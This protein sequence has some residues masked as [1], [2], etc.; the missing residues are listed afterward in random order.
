MISQLPLYL[1]NI[2]VGYRN[3]LASDIN[4]E[5][6]PREFVTVMG[7]N[8]FG[9]TTL[10]DCLM[11]LSSPL[12]GDIRF[13]GRLYSGQFRHEINQRVGWVISQKENYPLFSTVDVFLK[14]IAPLYTTWNWDFCHRL[15][16]AFELDTRKKLF[17]LSMGEH[18]KVR[19]VKALSFEPSLIVLDELT[20]NL[21]P[22]SKESLLAA[23]LDLFSS[24][25]M[26]VLYVSHSNEEAVKL[27][28][29]IFEMKADG[30]K[31]VG[32]QNV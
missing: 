14:R 12:S 21:S 13:W 15:C 18:S 1:K 29:R 17:H 31:L 16:K 32:G 7:E 25:K 24:K 2:S 3:P 19:L 10:V 11:G 30:L 20:A 9:K 6:A 26:S 27:S 8:G 22:S 28:D 4:L 23:L 5:I